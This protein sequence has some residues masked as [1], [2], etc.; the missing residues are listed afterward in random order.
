V[1]ESLRTAFFS[2][3]DLPFAAY[4]VSTGA[5]RLHEVRVNVGR[6]AEFV[7]EDPHGTAG[8]LAGDFKVRRLTCEPVAFHEALRSLRRQIDEQIRWNQQPK[9]E[10]RQMHVHSSR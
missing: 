10:P 6:R 8:T 2:T 5:L 3:H 4:C 7:F 9:D 1:S